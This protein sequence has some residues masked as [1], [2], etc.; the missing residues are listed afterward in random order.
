MPLSALWLFVY[1]PIPWGAVL[2]IILYRHDLSQLAHPFKDRS[3]VKDWKSV[4]QDLGIN[5]KPSSSSGKRTGRV[6]VLIH[7]LRADIS[8]RYPNAR[9]YI[10]IIAL[11]AGSSLLSSAMILRILAGYASLL[12]PRFTMM[13]SAGLQ[14]VS[15]LPS[16]FAMQRYFGSFPAAP[17]K[18]HL[19]KRRLGS[20]LRY[21]ETL[22][23]SSSSSRSSN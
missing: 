14:L 18:F 13:V 1:T 8:D 3:S 10:L 19:K 5:F 2:C 9:F 20:L 7:R 22:E 12:N 21:K 15:A 6:V 11:V 17:N 16:V 4:L 23:H